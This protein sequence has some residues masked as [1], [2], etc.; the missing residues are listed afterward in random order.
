MSMSGGTARTAQKKDFVTA[1]IWPFRKARKPAKAITLNSVPQK[2]MVG[3]DG[4]RNRNG[5]LVVVDVVVVVTV[6][7]VDVLVA[8]VVIVCVVVVVL[9]EVA[10]VVVDELVLVD[11]VRVPVDVVAVHVD[12]E[13]VTVRVLVLVRVIVRVVVVGV[14]VVVAVVVAGRVVVIVVVTVVVACA[15]M[16]C[17][18]TA[19]LFVR[20]GALVVENA[21]ARLGPFSEW[22]PPR[23]AVRSR[24]RS[25]RDVFRNSLAS[26]SRSSS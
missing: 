9:V 16:S 7:V 3:N 11:D 21:A 17:A 12:V 2:P 14:S 10:V 23:A 4:Y 19:V 15:L 18:A 22:C 5:D 13:L 26:T 20:A 25:G 24:C 6:V 1:H 8:V